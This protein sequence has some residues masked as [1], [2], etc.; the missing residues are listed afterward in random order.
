L[1]VR[2]RS[3]DHRVNLAHR[4]VLFPPSIRHR[5]TSLRCQLKILCMPSFAVL[6]NSLL[7]TFD[8]QRCYMCLATLR[9]MTTCGYCPR[10]LCP[11]CIDIGATPPAKN[12]V[13][14]CLHCHEQVFKSDPYPVSDLLLCFFSLKSVKNARVFIFEAIRAS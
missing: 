11:N 1:S 12:V 7:T 13:F 14:L 2:F 10:A 6:E 5:F 4:R 8:M 9:P 3:R